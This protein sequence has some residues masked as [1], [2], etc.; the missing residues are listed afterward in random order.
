M[1][2]NIKT[3]LYKISYGLYIV[4]SALEEKINGQVCN[5]FFQITSN[6]YTV[7]VALNK[8]NLT[9]EYVKKSGIFTANILGQSHHNLV[10]RFGYRSGREFDKFKNIEYSKEITG[11]PIL[12]NCLAYL[13]CKVMPEK[14]LD[15]VT[16]NLFIAEVVGGQVFID[17][18][19]MTY[20]YY[21]KTK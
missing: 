10:R 9:N 6:P 2:D 19:P 21:R 15:I 20:E 12:N 1:E 16:H 18:E 3:A 11:A 14:T 5:T 13:E 17:E 4:T 8:D 7:A